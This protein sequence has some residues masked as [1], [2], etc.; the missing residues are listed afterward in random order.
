M[1]FIFICDKRPVAIPSAQGHSLQVLICYR[2][3]MSQTP[4]KLCQKCSELGPTTDNFHWQNPAWHMTEVPGSWIQGAGSAM[5]LHKETNQQPHPHLQFRPLRSD[6]REAAKGCQLV[7]FLRAPHR[8]P[9]TTAW[10]CSWTMTSF[11]RGFPLS[12]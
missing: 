11:C 7:V 9:E 8:N 4:P 3:R 1:P 5:E 2:Q 10:G 6:L 12:F